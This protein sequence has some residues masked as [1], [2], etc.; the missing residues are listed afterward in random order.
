[1]TFTRENLSLDTLRNR[2]TTALIGL[3]WFNVL[4]VGLAAFWMGGAEP[5]PAIAISTVLAA[6]PTWSY[7]AL[8]PGATT[9]I[10]RPPPAASRPIE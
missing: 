2:F 1:M 10:Q 7:F 3:L 9:S 5:I 6:L 8:K 4:L